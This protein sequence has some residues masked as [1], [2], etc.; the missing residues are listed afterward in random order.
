[1]QE[2]WKD[3]KDYEGLYQVSNL[4]R[5]KSLGKTVKYKDGRTYTYPEKILNQNLARGYLYVNVRKMD[6]SKRYVAVH[7][8]V[9]ETF[10]PNLNNLPQVNHKDE[11]KENN[12]VTNLEWCDRIYN[13]NY[14]TLPQRV[15][16][17]M[18]GNK[19]CVGRVYSE[20]TKEKMRNSQRLRRIREKRE[21]IKNGII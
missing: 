18:R 16:E 3:I 7:R 21:E 15:S 14:G 20:A 5:I 6:H 19:N 12:C 17:R 9:A 10:I 4:G 1:M 2:I 11:N 8:L 13:C